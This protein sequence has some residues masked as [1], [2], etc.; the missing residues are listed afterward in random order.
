MAITKD[1]S[2]PK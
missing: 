1:K 2:L